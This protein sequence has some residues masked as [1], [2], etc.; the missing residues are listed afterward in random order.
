MQHKNVNKKYKFWT[1]AGLSDLGAL[2]R[3]SRESKHLPLR[4]A[5]QLISQNAGVEI[6]Y[7]TLASVENASGEPKFNTLAA[8]AAAEFVEID[9]RKLN[10]FD[11]IAIASETFEVDM[12]ALAEL[13]SD[14][15]TRNELT[16]SDFAQ[17]AMVG[18]E[19]LEAVMR[20]EP[21]RTGDLRLITGHL[22]NPSTG[23]K[24]GT[25]EEITDYC[26][27]IKS[28]NKSWQQNHLIQNSTN[29]TNLS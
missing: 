25:L 7:R 13:I 23:N 27:L 11:F 4:N 1:K 9:G 14:H 28:S 29:L 26:G 17:I 24:F 15:L 2:I 20:G 8:I 21:I 16:L 19:D 5:A 10:I 12:N 18:L 6:S 22:T 3:S